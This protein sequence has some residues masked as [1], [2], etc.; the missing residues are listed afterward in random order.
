LKEV[1]KKKKKSNKR[2]KEKE[3]EK[4]KVRNNRW[5]NQRTSGLLK[6]ERKRE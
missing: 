4:R 3:K 6:Q 5:W 1:K 2:T